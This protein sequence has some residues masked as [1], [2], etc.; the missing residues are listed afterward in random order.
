VLKSLA[1]LTLPMA[2]AAAVPIPIG[3]VHLDTDAMGLDA[4]VGVAFLPG[5]RSGANACYVEA[6]RKDPN[7]KGEIAFVL[8][9]PPGEGRFL[10][11]L[12]GKGAIDK[13][14]VTCVEKVFGSF[15]HYANKEPFD[16]IEGTL[17][18]EP[19]WITAPAPPTTEEARAA[20]D[21]TYSPSD[22]VRISNAVLRT[23]SEYS[24]HSSD[25]VRRSYVYDLD[26]V[27]RADG[28]EAD[29]QHNG[30]YKVF[31]SRPYDASRYAGHM[32]ESH[33]RKAGDRAVDTAIVVFRLHYYPSVP[34]SWELVGAR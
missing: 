9:P 14:L 4:K 24:D 20:L 34:K 25:E 13:T 28:Y 17:R 11:E 16:R 2:L 31:S 22:V 18:F 19:E 33:P 10:V 8:K 27:F 12:E 5:I 29:C 30:P 26:L 3:G 21:R 6:L 1:R 32:C 7:Q 23:V 15:Y